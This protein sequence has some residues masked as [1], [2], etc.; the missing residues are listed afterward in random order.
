[1]DLSDCVPSEYRLPGYRQ[2]PVERI[3]AQCKVFAPV[4]VSE[5]M[6]WLGSF[7]D[8][9][10]TKPMAWVCYSLATPFP[11]AKVFIVA[12]APCK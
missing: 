2:V 12:E 4:K 5:A 6:E 11:S 10:Y 8:A 3:H 9:G 7:V 1:M